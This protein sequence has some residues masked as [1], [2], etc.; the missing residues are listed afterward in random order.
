MTILCGLQ[1]EPR[2]TH[3][4]RGRT[5]R[6][7]RVKF[8]R[9]KPCN[10]WEVSKFIPIDFERSCSLSRFEIIPSAVSEQVTSRCRIF[11]FASIEHFMAHENNSN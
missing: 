11:E 5:Q 4:M 7:F 10:I 6:R 9:N 2:A 8:S 3:L 1:T